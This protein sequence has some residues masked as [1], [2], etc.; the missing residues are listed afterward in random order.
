MM[1][2]LVKSSMSDKSWHLKW[3]R[4][5]RAMRNGAVLPFQAAPDH[6]RH[7][8]PAV[9]TS[10]AVTPPMTGMAISMRTRSNMRGP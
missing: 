1:E 2:S 6:D 8:F 10:V 4:T 7:C 5:A 3:A 9:F